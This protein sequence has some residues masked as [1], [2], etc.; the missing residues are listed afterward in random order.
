MVAR[1]GWISDER[2]V[3]E[4]SI[5][6]E[7]NIHPSLRLFVNQ[8][9]DEL[10]LSSHRLLCKMSGQSMAFRL[11]EIKSVE[12]RKRTFHT[13]RIAM[14]FNDAVFHVTLTIRDTQLRMAV[15]QTLS[16]LITQRPWQESGYRE[17]PSIGGIVTITS[18]ARDAAANAKSVA[19]TG[20]AD[21]SSLKD[22]ASEVKETIQKL[23]NSANESELSMYKQMLSEY[24][25][26][27]TVTPCHLT[28]ESKIESLIVQAVR[29]SPQGV[30]FAHDLYCVINR[31]LKLETIISPKEFMKTV[32][33][34][35]RSSAV[36]SML[37]DKYTIVYNPSRFDTARISEVILRYDTEFFGIEEFAKLINLTDMRLAQ[38]ILI[39]IELESGIICRDDGGEFGDRVFYKNTYFS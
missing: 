32:D 23:R 7:I 19:D 9:A 12:I 29:S 28:V 26:D 10:Q 5:S 13:D 21:I 39:R 18:R 37:V 31:G 34:L 14:I 17:S 15:Y 24:G 33:S 11:D 22:F 6:S 1:I 38:L 3:S 20:L 30:L 2:L 16:R 8:T 36:A 4:Y 35:C 25:L 27:S